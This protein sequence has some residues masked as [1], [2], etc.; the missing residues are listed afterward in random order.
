MPP[1]Q[2]EV[3]GGPILARPASR[4]GHPLSM[5]TRRLARRPDPRVI[6]GLGAYFLTF[7]LVRW[8]ISPAL[9]LDEAEQALLSQWWQWGYSAQPPLYTWLQA[10]LNAIVGPNLLSLS[11]LRQALLFAT[12]YLVYLVGLRVLRRHDLALAATLSL[13]LLPQVVWENQREH[14]HSLLV[15]TLA[16]ATLWQVLRLLEQRTLSGYLAL[17]LLGALG[18]LAKYNYALFAAALGLALLSLPAGR[19]LLLDLRLAATVALALLV[20]TPHLLWLLE[21]AEVGAA[22]AEKLQNQAQPTGPANGFGRLLLSTLTFLTPLWL[23][24]LGLFPGAPAALAAR[25]HQ[26]PHI[27]LLLRYLALVWPLLMLTLW[28]TDADQVKDRWLQPLL[29][30]VPIVLFAGVVPTPAAQRQLRWFRAL[31]LAAGLLV[32]L[33]GALRIPLAPWTGVYTRLHQ[34]IAELAWEIDARGDR[35]NLVLTDHYHLAGMLRTRWPHRR[36]LGPRADYLLPDPATLIAAA[37]GVLLIW[38]AG[39]HPDLPTAL[40]APAQAA[41]LMPEAVAP[42]YLSAPLRFSSDRMF[43]L[44]LIALP[45][46]EHQ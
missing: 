8:L 44:G 42:V 21:H 31:A 13:L 15:L 29:F 2:V 7:A 10:G 34:P 1:G 33:I 11:L 32:L 17:G 28:T 38:D 35:A 46:V 26:L 23:V 36:T 25:R 14:T 6:L 9:E 30:V 27:D 40:A 24:F 5:R 20:L 43:Q 16:A 12:Y 4:L 18:L 45:G 37:D 39:R 22:V 41:G 3:P 19:R